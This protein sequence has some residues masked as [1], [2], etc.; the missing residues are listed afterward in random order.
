MR[1]RVVRRGRGAYPA[2][3]QRPITTTLPTAPAA[4]MLWDTTGRLPVLALDFDAKHGHGPRSTEHDAHDALRLLTETGLKPVADRSPSGGWHIYARLPQPAAAWEVRQTATALTRRWPTLDPSPL[5]NPAHGCLRPPGSTHPTG[6]HQRLLGPLTAAVSA[7]T[8]PP[9]ADAWQRLRDRVGAPTISLQPDPGELGTA[10]V[11]V[12]RRTIAADADTLAR[13]GTHPRRDFASPSE[14]RYSVICSAVA[15]GWELADV[16]A[17]LRTTW[18]W[19]HAS[20]GTK[21]HS[22]LLRDWRK[23]KN[24][25]TRNL[26]QKTVR[27]P[28]TSQHRPQAHAPT[29]VLTNDDPHLLLRKFTTH[30]REH[31]RRHHYSPVLRAV[32]AAL[33]WAGHVQGRTLINVGVRALA[34]QAGLHF[35]T[36]A[37]ALHTLADDGLI[38]RLSTG[39]GPDA[40]LWRLN[41][42]LAEHARPA[43]GRRVALRPVF[44][45]LGGHRAGEIYELLRETH[46]PLHV[47]DIVTT[48]GYPRQRVHET[49]QLL[50]GFQLATVEPHTGWTLGPANPDT[51]ARQLGGWQHWHDQHHRHTQQRAHWRA[52]LQRHRPP[53]ISTDQLILDELDAALPEP[54]WIAEYATGTSPPRHSAVS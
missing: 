49:L 5:L 39:R 47:R 19:L 12:T 54:D 21:H 22:A 10:A 9:P 18:T 20:Y 6:G 26:R 15:A 3:A 51:L 35:D 17:A 30:T 1:V 36:V 33:T 23:A 25:R 32:L 42:E 7:F 31:A 53:T 44:R 16:E 37:G 24:Q 13:T 40:D 4:V 41:T 46:H 11:G 2:S 8:A 34:E 45:T 29:P 43:R 48:L 28:D 14:A 52:W 50:A 38:M 27:S